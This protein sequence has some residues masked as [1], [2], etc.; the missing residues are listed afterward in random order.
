MPTLNTPNPKSYYN[1]SSSDVRNLLPFIRRK[2][3]KETDEQGE[4]QIIIWR[5][6]SKFSKYEKLIINEVKIILLIEFFTNFM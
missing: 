1:L 2:H 4:E 6:N 5:G 3:A